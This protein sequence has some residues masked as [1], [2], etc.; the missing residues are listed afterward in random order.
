MPFLG[1]HA[2]LAVDD[3]FRR[4]LH[5]ALIQRATTV[6]NTAGAPADQ[7]ELAAQILGGASTFVE[8]F[9]W[10]VA[11]TQAIQDNLALRQGN[12]ALIDDAA[13]EQAV[14]DALLRLL[15]TRAAGAA[16]VVG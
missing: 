12:P 6:A 14:L 16:R 4:R 7:K 13:I 10:P 3:G 8:A 15:A 11:G 1:A 5:A 9:A 2:A